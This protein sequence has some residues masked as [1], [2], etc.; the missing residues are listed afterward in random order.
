MAELFRPMVDWELRTLIAQLAEK[1]TTI[2][3]IGAGSKRSIGRP[4]E[5]SALLSTV[6]L[7]G[8][9][10]YEPNELVMSARAGTPLSQIE[11]ELASRGQML[12]FEPLEYGALLD[13]SE[14]LQTIGGIFA[15][16]NSGA[17]RLA[18]GAARDH[19]IGL[20][21]VNGRAE[22]F[23]SGGRV[24][25]N[26]TGYDVAR[27]LVGSW[28]TLAVFTELTFKV[29][30][31]PDDTVTLIYLGLEE[32][33]ALELMGLA[34]ATPYEVSGAVHLCAAHAARLNVLKFNNG[35]TSFTAL[36]IENFMKSV[37]YRKNKLAEH[38]APYG[39]P[40]EL[41]SESSLPFWAQLRKLAQLKSSNS[42]IWRLS[43]LPNKAAELVSVLRQHM[44]L[45]VTYDWSGG[46]VWLEV[47][48]NEDG[49][50][51]DIRRSLSI[52][53]GHATLIRADESLRKRID[54]FQPQS[55]NLEKLTRG[56]KKAFDPHGLLNPGRMYRML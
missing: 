47:P 4:V 14:G 1:H 48:S 18:V 30:P 41:D 53:G 36:R 2:E 33:L 29:F 55:S 56:L 10:L 51:A 5:A 31:L 38:L 44:D 17:R 34:L 42:L 7:K 32:N 43:T 24:M 49:Y 8:I 21:G 6:G 26:V 11:K 23:K 50:V 12:S 54:V 28:G 15:T 22:Y 52:F 45:N 27:G 25:K 13:S 37:Q 39:S 9:S 16:N 20:S 46:L 40:L 19:L 35:D 3:I